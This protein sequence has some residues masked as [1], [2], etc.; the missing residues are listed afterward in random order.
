VNEPALKVEERALM[1]ACRRRDRGALE[2]VFRREGPA[3]A[4]LI[5]R[6]VGD[7]AERD[8]LLQATLA[9][10]LVAF[11]RFRGDAAVSTWLARIAVNVVRQSW[12][13]RSVQRRARLELVPL[14]PAP[15]A[16]GPDRAAQARRHLER[17]YHHLGRM[18]VAKRLA[19]VLHVIDGRPIDEVAALTRASRAATRSRVFWGRRALISSARRDPLLAGWL[20]EI[21][22][23]SR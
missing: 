13:R 17:V 22:E 23:E 10:A 5:A 21:E 1:D 3:L 4:R 8:D 2:E 7:S 12:R 19:F 16:A 11:P 9:E 20:E 18:S 15:A 6:M 14:E